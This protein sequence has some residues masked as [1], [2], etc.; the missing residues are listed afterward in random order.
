MS[1]NKTEIERVIN[2]IHAFFTDWVGGRCP[3]DPDTFRQRALDHISDNLVAIFPAGRSF[4]KSDFREY[5]GSIY[6][7]NPK[8][9]I[10]IRDIRLRHLAPEMAVV[11]YEEWQRDAQDSEKPNNGRLTTMVLGNGDAGAGPQILQVHETWL[12]DEIVEAADFDF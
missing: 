12:P 11:T 8:F 9:R 1:M 5:M 7:S 3:G 4:G 2:D 6:G 10:R